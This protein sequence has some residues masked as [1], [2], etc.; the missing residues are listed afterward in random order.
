[1]SRLK[2]RLKQLVDTARTQ[3]GVPQRR[4]LYGELGLEFTQHKNG[5]EQLTLSRVGVAPAENEWMTVLDHWPETLPTP[6]PVPTPHKEGRVY[7]L[8][9]RWPRPVETETEVAVLAA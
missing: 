1:M 8:V 2:F 5:D 3:P 9:G 4:T 6:R 7:K